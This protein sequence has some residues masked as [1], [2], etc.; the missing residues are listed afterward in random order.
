MKQQKKRKDLYYERHKNDPAFKARRAAWARAYRAAH[1][2]VKAYQ[3]AYRKKYYAAHK[4][5]LN[6]KQRLY[7]D[8][9]RNERVNKFKKREREALGRN[10][11][12]ALITRS[13]KIKKE[14]VTPAMIAKRRR[15]IRAKRAAKK[16]G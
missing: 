9:T 12:I 11:I 13:G 1:P 15:Q 3:R 14:D 2:E 5:E 8:K 6:A 4:D 10:Y 7:P 16:G